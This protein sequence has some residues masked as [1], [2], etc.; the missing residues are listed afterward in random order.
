M[1]EK[2]GISYNA[3]IFTNG[4]L[5]DREMALKMKRYH[6]RM[7]QIS[8]DGPPE[9]HNKRRPLKT[10]GGT[11]DRI[12][13]NIKDI[14]DVMPIL[15]RF[16]LDKTNAN[17]DILSRLLDELEKKEIPKESNI[18]VDLAQIQPFTAACVEFAKAKGFDRRDYGKMIVKLAPLI[19]ER[20]YYFAD[21]RLAPV[22]A[23]CPSTWTHSIIVAPNGDIY[24]CLTTIGDKREIIG[25]IF[26]STMH[27]TRNLA[28]WL[29]WNPFERKQCQEC[30]ILPLCMGG[31]GC[32]YPDVAAKGYVRSKI[33]CS[34]LKFNMKEMIEL[35]YEQRKK[36]KN[37]IQKTGRNRF[38]HI[39]S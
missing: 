19:I 2:R 13:Q 18:N 6:V 16:N 27:L 31:D 7:A 1:T 28:K 11:F 17:P 20:G 3:A 38:E 37:T 10:G 24:R 39:P 33:R 34:P 12:L 22:P 5:F 25:N 9:I 35:V 30:N 32:P 14:S 21:Y 15:L 8:L 4:Y 26:Q 23:C 29:A 36:R